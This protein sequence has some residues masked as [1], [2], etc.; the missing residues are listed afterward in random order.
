MTTLCKRAGARLAS[1][2]SVPSLTIEIHDSIAPVA[3]DWD[4]L[5]DRVG[6]PPFMRPGWFAAW[7]P[8]FAGGRPV[9]VTAR[10]GERLVGLMALQRRA[11]GL[12]APTNAHTPGF[13]VL[14]EDATAA[15]AIAEAVVG[16]PSRGLRLDYVSLEDRG[17]VAIEK[18]A[19]AKA[20]R[21]LRMTVRRSPYLALAGGAEDVDRRLSAK[22]AANLRRLERRLS[23]QGHTEI[24]VADGRDRREALLEEGFRLEASGWKAQRGTAIRSSETT[25]RFYAALAVWAAERGLLRLAF[26]RLDGRSVAFELA[27]EDAHAY[28]FLKGGY[29]PVMRRFAPGKLLARA[30]VARA[31]AIGLGRFEFLGL[32]EP[33]KLE[34]APEFHERTLLRVFPATAFG[35]L[36]RAAQTAY[37]RYAR[38]L[39]KR[40]VAQLR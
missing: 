38:P 33:W 19:A 1:I 14:A 13:D 30:M 27:L 24:E 39:A 20:H 25:R 3:P 40:T 16:L 8:A 6:A 15:G 12:S 34:W 7:W 37:L 29:D 35:S 11:G 4:G 2:L 32:A 31:A 36:D 28:Y 26:L 21:V 23:A 9:V 10:R 17:V 22:V 5:V 18:A